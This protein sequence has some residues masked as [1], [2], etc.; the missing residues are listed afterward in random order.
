MKSKQYLAAKANE[1]VEAF[2]K[3]T[4]NHPNLVAAIK[5]AQEELAARQ[6][7]PQDILEQLVL[8]SYRIC[9]LSNLKISSEA[10]Q[11]LKEM[12]QLSRER[13]IIPFFRYDP[14]T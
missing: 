8:D 4:P 12:E 10:F 7:A 9:R 2:A 5:K 13:S 1:L 3:E 14:W 11:I 6:I